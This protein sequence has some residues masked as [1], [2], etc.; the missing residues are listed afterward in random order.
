MQTI[1]LPTVEFEE[2][3]GIFKYTVRRDGEEQGILER[4]TLPKACGTSQKNPKWIFT[5]PHSE[6]GSHWDTLEEAQDALQE[7]LMIPDWLLYKTYSEVEEAFKRGELDGFKVGRRVYISETSVDNYL[8]INLEPTLK[9]ISQ[10]I[11]NKTLLLNQRAFQGNKFLYYFLLDRLNK[12]VSRMANNCL[13]CE[14]K[15]PE[16]RIYCDECLI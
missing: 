6:S 3:S 9:Q 16:D 14:S 8:K 13:K 15:I 12:G 1:N 2:Q 4:S 10:K 5:G 11:L 7:T